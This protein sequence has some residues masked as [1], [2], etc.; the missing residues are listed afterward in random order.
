MTYFKSLLSTAAKLTN[1]EIRKMKIVF[2]H[3]IASRLSSTIIWICCQLYVF[4]A[5]DIMVIFLDI[6]WQEFLFNINRKTILGWNKQTLVSC[7]IFFCIYWIQLN[8]RISYCYRCEATLLYSFHYCFAVSDVVVSRNRNGN[9]PSFALT[10]H[11]RFPIW[12]K[13]LKGFEA[14]HFNNVS[15]TPSRTN[16]R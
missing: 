16:A 6:N 13:M 3:K 9:D 2:L 4:T 7:E 10:R 15:I 8:P 12:S 11:I 14:L 1:R 5:I